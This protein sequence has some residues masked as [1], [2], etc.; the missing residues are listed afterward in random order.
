MYVCK[1]CG[2]KFNTP[3][4]EWRHRKLNPGVL[5]AID[6]QALYYPLKVCPRCK[7][8]AIEEVEC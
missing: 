8:D 2:F 1:N 5:L 6:R 3:E 7:S 4:I